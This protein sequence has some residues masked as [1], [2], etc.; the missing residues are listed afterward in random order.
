[1]DS[2]DIVVVPL[3]VSVFSWKFLIIVVFFL[4]ISFCDAVQQVV[5]EGWERRRG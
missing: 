1:M 4:E 5:G 3:A 2:R